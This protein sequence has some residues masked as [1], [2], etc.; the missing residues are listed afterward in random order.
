MKVN[1]KKLYLALARACMNLSEAAKAAGMPYQSAKNVYN[2]RGAT[3]ATIGKLCRALGVDP[4]DI[5]EEED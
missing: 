1:R 4:A 3:P 2:G 5:I